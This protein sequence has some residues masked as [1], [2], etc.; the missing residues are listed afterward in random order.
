MFI[1]FKPCFSILLGSLLFSCSNLSSINENVQT[2]VVPEQWQQSTALLTVDNNW[3][4][5]LEN[6]ALQELINK[7]LTKNYQLQAQAYR[8][9]INKQS[10][11]IAGSELWP[12]LDL[13]FQS[14]RNKTTEP[15]SYS[16][17]HD[18]DLNLSYELDL[19]GKL[20]AAERQNH[21]NYLAELAAF[22][23]AKQQLLV[24]VVTTWF[25]IVEADKL[26]TLYQQQVENSQQNLA[27]IEAGYNAGLNESLDVYLT[28]NELNNKLAQVA[29]QTT[30][31]TKLV[32][33]LEQLVG[34]YPAGRLLVEAELPLI[35]N[36][37]PLGLPSELISRKPALKASWY[38]LL[39]QDA[40]LAYA[41][42]Q[43]FPSLSLSASIGDSQND[44][45]DLL[46]SSSLAWSLLGRIST[47]LFNAGRL[48]ANEEKVRLTLK[49]TEQLYLDTLYS[50]FSDVENAITTEHSLKQRYQ[51]MLAAQENANIAATLSFEQYQSGLVSYTTVLDAQ[52][53]L[54]QAQSTLIQ[55]KRQLLTNRINLHFY[56]GGDFAT[57][58]LDPEAPQIK[59]E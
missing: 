47:P 43:R 10:V 20:S 24:D 54:Y 6:S 5:A 13:S 12:E 3:L 25:A 41:H 40:G 34:D 26:L 59:A 56:L 17:S 15:D 31:K 53:R 49:Q 27:I 36:H 1:K 4:T 58:S 42:K 35:E 2:P 8:V 9:E 38:Q 32:R 30:E 22:E 37:I 21:Y 50:A 33:N 16:N 51:A 52:E 14:R 11:I 44:I 57:S 18:L 28:R 55:L 46:S 23:E 29:N 39:A 48:A 45:G 19:W 7:A